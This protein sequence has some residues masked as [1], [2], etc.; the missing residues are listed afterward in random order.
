VAAANSTISFNIAR[1]GGG[2]YQAID[3]DGNGVVLTSSAVLRNIPDNC[4]PPGTI[5]GCNG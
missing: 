1:G 4:A 5:M 3:G 2:I